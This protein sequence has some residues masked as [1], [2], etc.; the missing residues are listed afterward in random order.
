MNTPAHAILNLTV[1]GR[2]APQ[3]TLPLFV[4]AVLPD[5]PMLVFFTW[6]TLVLGTP[7]SVIWGEAYFRD[8]W[9]DF[10]DLFNS[11]PLL[12]LAMLLCWRFQFEWGRWLFASALV[13][14]FFDLP[15]HHDD[16]H[17]HFLP[18]SGFRFASPVSYWDPAHHGAIAAFGEVVVVCVGSAVL[19]KRHEHPAARSVLA[20][21]ALASLV[22]YGVFYGLPV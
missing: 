13:H 1:L 5:A 8:G 18:L 10:F 2:D 22:G 16:G 20:L 11:I 6:E 4:G 12:L 17:R 21:A 15:L 3:R 9:Q 7:Q 14:C 19:W